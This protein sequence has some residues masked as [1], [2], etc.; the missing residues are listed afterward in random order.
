MTPVPLYILAGGQSR[1][2]GSDKARAWFEGSPLIG[3]IARQL[4]PIAARVTVVADRADKYADLGLMT[5]RDAV[6]G[7]GPLGGLVSALEHAAAHER[8]DWA[9]IV[10]CDWLNP[11]PEIIR[12]LAARISAEATAMAYRDQR[13]HPF[14]G[15]Y[16]LAV[17]S[18]AAAQLERGDRAMWRLLDALPGAVGIAPGAPSALQQANTPEDLG[19]A[20]QDRNRDST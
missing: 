15:L 2:F 9:C 20:A 17:R 13:W 4:E 12:S 19:D 11:D 8:S 18:A 3:R 6:P 16:H 7:Q 1:R 14:P 5:I 10:S